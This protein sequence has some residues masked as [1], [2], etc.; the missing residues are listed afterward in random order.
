MDI[1]TWF[2]IGALG[3]AASVS[4]FLVLFD[5]P[6]HMGK[7]VALIILLAGVIVVFCYELYLRMLREIRIT[8]N[9]PTQARQSATFENL[10]LAQVHTMHRVDQVADLLNK[11]LEHMEG[12]VHH[13]QKIKELLDKN[14]EKLEDKETILL[15]KN[16]HMAQA[17]NLHNTD[18]TVEL[19]KKLV[20]DIQTLEKDS[21]LTDQA[22]KG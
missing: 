5:I 15:L 18:R 13:E 3:L 1:T 6:E 12:S 19:L 16:I 14:L 22:Y 2:K 8:G 10:H 17:H 21:K 4:F 20:E 11:I 7:V 9:V